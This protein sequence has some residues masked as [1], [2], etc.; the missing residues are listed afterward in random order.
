MQKLK[1]AQVVKS[2]YTEKEHDL[3]NALLYTL[4]TRTFSENTLDFWNNQDD[5]SSRTFVF[6]EAELKKASKY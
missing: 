1:R 3:L 4:Q 2:S 6:T 5:T